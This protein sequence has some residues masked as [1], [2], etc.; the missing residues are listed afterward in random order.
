MLSLSRNTVRRWLAVAAALA[1]FAAGSAAATE[2][3]F[4]PRVTSRI[5]YDDNIQITAPANAIDG[6]MYRISPGMEATATGDAWRF[7]G[8]AQIDVIRFD[9][10]DFDT[11]DQRARMTIGHFSERRQIQLA[12]SLTRQSQRTS[13][14]LSSGDLT[15]TASRVE[16]VEVRP[17]AFFQLSELYGLSI[18]GSFTNQHYKDFERYTDYESKGLDVTLARQLS[19]RFLLEFTAFY[20]EYEAEP[21]PDLECVRGIFFIFA[22]LECEQF[23][24][25]GTSETLGAQIGLRSALSETYQWQVSVGSREVDSSQ[26][27]SDVLTGCIFTLSF[28][29]LV[30]CSPGQPST[31]SA[32]E[33]GLILSTSLDYK[34]PRWS[35]ELSLQRSVT[36]VSLGFLIESDRFDGVSRFR[37]TE[38]GTLRVAATLQ[39]AESV[40]S[41]LFDRDFNALTVSF[42]WRLTQRWQLNPGVRWR[43]QKNAILGSEG[44]S[45]SAF[46]DIN[47]RAKPTQFSR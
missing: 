1:T 38:R 9:T 26:A 33:S 42:P 28:N 23:D 13:E 34:G 36:P 40:T 11:D 37:M 27:R 6:F 31:I 15:G 41:G 24:A 8:D 46:L 20:N 19:E 45:Y 43:Q 2:Y 22:V 32:S 14:T 47:F 16:T 21:K 44:E 29:T 10:D 25:V 18:G 35:Y 12:A 4:K 30:P 5:S 39:R 3:V 17:V 7:T